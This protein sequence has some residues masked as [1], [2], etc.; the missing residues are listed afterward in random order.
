MHVPGRGRHALPLATHIPAIQHPSLAQLLPEQQ[1]WPGPP[2]DVPGVTPPPEGATP[3]L[4]AAPPLRAPPEL[5]VGIVG[6]EL[7]PLPPAVPMTAP[8]PGPPAPRPPFTPA[9][10]VPVA[11]PAP[12][13]PT[14]RPPF[15]PAPAVPMAAP[16]PE[17][18]APRPPTGPLAAALPILPSFVS[19]VRSPPAPL[20]LLLESSQPPRPVASAR[21]ARPGTTSKTQGR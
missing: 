18:P 3:P 16:A 17:P 4:P 15:T 6:F 7:P 14:P 11:A 19:A 2:Q 10:A 21:T 1:Y 12:E 9:P 8:A 13:P 20:S 5:G